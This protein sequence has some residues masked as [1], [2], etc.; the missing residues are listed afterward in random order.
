MKIVKNERNLKKFR[1]SSKRNLKQRNNNFI[2]N[3]KYI[4]S[5]NA[6]YI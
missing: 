1:K 5:E 3:A 2:G 4:L 6:K